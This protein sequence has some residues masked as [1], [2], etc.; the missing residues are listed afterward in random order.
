MKGG[1]RKETRKRARDASGER[2]TDDNHAAA[3]DGG[4]RL[5]EREI[6]RPPASIGVWKCLTGNL[7]SH[8]CFSN[9][10]CVLGVF[11]VHSF[12]FSLS[13][14]FMES[15][16]E[17]LGMLLPWLAVRCDVDQFFYYYFNMG[18]GFKPVSVLVHG[19]G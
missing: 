1:W 18:L 7:K 13:L 2:W 19:H 4:W 3:C 5:R 8:G 12:E 10:V 16:Q 11:Y 6:Q 17:R 9:W 14:F 15:A